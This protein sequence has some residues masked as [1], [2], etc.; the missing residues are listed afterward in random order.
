MTEKEQ[1]LIELVLKAQARLPGEKTN[2]TELETAVQAVLTER[3]P[4]E[5]ERTLRDLCFRNWDAQVA[6]IEFRDKNRIGRSLCLKFAKEWVE[7]RGRELPT[8]V[9]SEF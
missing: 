8:G 4:A 7:E 5:Y 2:Y 6:S 3:S 9:V 1:E